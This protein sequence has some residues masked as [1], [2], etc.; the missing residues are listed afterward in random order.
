MQ[1]VENIQYRLAGAVD[2]SAPE[3]GAQDPMRVGVQA[4]DV[5]R[6]HDLKRDYDDRYGERLTWDDMIERCR[7]MPDP[8]FLN[9]PTW[10]VLERIPAS[11]RKA[12]RPQS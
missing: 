3:H 11:P 5:E 7:L 12:E 9:L 8:E 2:R 10:T 1:L 4:G 6:L